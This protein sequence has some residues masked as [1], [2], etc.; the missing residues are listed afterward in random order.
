MQRYATTGHLTLAPPPDDADF[1]NRAAVDEM[2]VCYALQQ[3]VEAFERR[4]ILQTLHHHGGHRAN[5]AAALEI[6]ER[7]LYRKIKAYGL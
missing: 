3:A 6:T 7:H 2:S 1:Q 4:H 5:T